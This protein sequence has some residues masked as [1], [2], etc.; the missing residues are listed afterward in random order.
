MEAE[1]FKAL[2]RFLYTDS[3][4]PEM[5]TE[6]EDARRMAKG[7][8]VAADTYDLQGLKLICAGKLIRHVNV[9]T[10]AELLALAVRHR[11]HLLK[12]ACTQVPSI[13]SRVGDGRGEQ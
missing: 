10:A 11:C 2:L 5:M 6:G 8:V 7:L 4:P 3:L 9:D 12:E 13:S 1:V